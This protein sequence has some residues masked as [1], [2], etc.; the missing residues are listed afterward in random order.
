MT[1]MYSDILKVAL[2]FFGGEG[3]LS[4]VRGL[5]R[6]FYTILG[7]RLGSRYEEGQFAALSDL[8]VKPG[9]RHPLL[10]H[11]LLPPPQPACPETPSATLAKKGMDCRRASV[12]VGL[13]TSTHGGQVHLIFNI[14]YML[15]TSAVTAVQEGQLTDLTA[16]FKDKQPGSSCCPTC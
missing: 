11:P 9:H 5:S 16:G 14:S 15:K 3:V 6:Y 12:S 1:K 4:F 2:W 10:K 8:T 13:I 7:S